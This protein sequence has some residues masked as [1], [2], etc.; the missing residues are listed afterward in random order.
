M[1]QLALTATE[2]FCNGVPSPMRAQKFWALFTIERGARRIHDGAFR[3]FNVGEHDCEMDCD[4]LDR[5]ADFN[6]VEE[7]SKRYANWGREHGIGYFVGISDDD[8][9]DITAVITH[10]VADA[11]VIAD[12]LG[13]KP[14]GVAN[15]DDDGFTFF[16]RAESFQS[17]TL[18]VIEIRDGKIVAVDEC[19]RFIPFGARLWHDD[20]IDELA[21]DDATKRIFE[22]LDPSILS[23]ILSSLQTEG[24]LSKLFCGDWINSDGEP[25]EGSETRFGD[26]INI[27]PSPEPSV[28]PDAEPDAECN[29]LEWLLAKDKQSM[30]P[31]TSKEAVDV[32]GNQFFDPAGIPEQLKKLSQWVL[33]RKQERDGK[34]TKIPCVEE[35]GQLVHRKK[36]HPLYSYETAVNLA[37]KFNC[38]IGIF[39]DPAR[40][41]LVGIDIDHCLDEQQKLEPRAKEVLDAV[42]K[43][44]IEISPSARGLHVLF[45]DDDNSPLTKNR[46]GNL[47]MYR[48]GRYFTVTGKNFGDPSDVA[49]KH[50]ILTELCNRFLMHDRETIEQPM[51]KIADS[52]WPS[53]LDECFKRIR[54]SKQH[55]KFFSLHNGIVTEYP[56]QSEAR[57]AYFAILAFYTNKNA[58]L[59]RRAFDCSELAKAP[60]VDERKINLDINKA[61]ETCKEVYTEK[62]RRG[63]D[64]RSDGGK[65][66]GTARKAD[67]SDY[68]I[69]DDI[70][71]SSV[72]NQLRYHRD[73]GAFMIYD[74][75]IWRV[76]NKDAEVRL[77]LA[78]YRQTPSSAISPARRKCRR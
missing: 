18:S 5:L 31:S 7:Q 63:G 74:D 6:L 50:G 67:T 21:A 55:H 3:D 59:M 66:S 72:G 35:G 37:I 12:I 24:D 41:H 33:W 56:S 53:V 43:T 47:E 8:V 69:A 61:I 22:Q 10:S 58:D 75:P 4:S 77:F 73:F 48:A 42:G 1:K 49:N 46:S 57:L 29:L 68:G 25:V 14:F 39:F 40:S 71:H 13:G 51:L 2:R 76:L 44:Y 36:E 70:V 27:T 60:G 20:P 23:K 34:T 78:R 54:Q 62:G 30:A 26:A 64:G 17:S 19:I 45:F 11:R 32:I 9:V 38:G 15:L 52:K 28:E 65:K 16:L